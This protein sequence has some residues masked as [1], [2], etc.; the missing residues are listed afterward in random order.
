MK[1]VVDDYSAALLFDYPHLIR[2]HVANRNILFF[3]RIVV[4]RD[5]RGVFL[6]GWSEKCG[7]AFERTIYC[8]KGKFKNAP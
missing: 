6:K 1:V 4:K 2:M 8:A 5:D 3:D 7:E